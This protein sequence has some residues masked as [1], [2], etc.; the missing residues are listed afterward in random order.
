MIIFYF[1]KLRA[2]SI[3]LPAFSAAPSFLQAVV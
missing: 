2:L 1:F 3:I